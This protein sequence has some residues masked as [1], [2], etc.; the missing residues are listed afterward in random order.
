MFDLALILVMILLT[1][2][3]PLN[4]FIGSDYARSGSLISFFFSWL[5]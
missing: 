5:T 1:I 2:H 4:L 3:Y